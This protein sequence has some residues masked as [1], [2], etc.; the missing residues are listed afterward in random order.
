MRDWIDFGLVRDFAA[1]KT[2]AYRLCTKP[3]GWVERYGADALVSYKTEAAL[4]QTLPELEEW[5]LLANQQFERVFG[6][7]LPKQ[8][9]ERNPPQL[10]SGDEQ[11]AAPGDGARAR[12]LLR[13][14]F[15]RR[16]FRRVLSRSA[17]KPPIRQANGAP[18]NAELF[19]LHLFVFR[20]RRL[21]RR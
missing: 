6:R 11:G 5:A 19:R 18:T 15:W 10:L 13:A 3:D 14:R 9:A 12:R 16:L 8:N 7:Y 17:R 1:E 4:E 21:G 20:R 2:D